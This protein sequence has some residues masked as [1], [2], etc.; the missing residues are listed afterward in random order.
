MI[1]RFSKYMSEWLYIQEKFFMSNSQLE[2]NG[3]ERSFPERLLIP[4]SGSA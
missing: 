2:S 3:V 1:E 4:N